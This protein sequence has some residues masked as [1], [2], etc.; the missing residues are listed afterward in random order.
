MSYKLNVSLEMYLR[1]HITEEQA[2]VLLGECINEITDLFITKAEIVGMCNNDSTVEEVV[3]DN[4]LW[5]DD[6]A[7]YEPYD[8]NLDNN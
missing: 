5:G 2:E 1:T 6:V 3:I 7:H 8:P 4:D